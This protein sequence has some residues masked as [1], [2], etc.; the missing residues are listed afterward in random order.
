MVIDRMLLVQRSST[1]LSSS[2]NHPQRKLCLF[3][4]LNIYSDGKLQQLLNHGGPVSIAEGRHLFGDIGINSTDPYLKVALNECKAS[5][6]KNAD[7]PNSQ[8][9]VRK[10]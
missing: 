4:R 9:V 8:V 1:I 7:D 2:R 10:G 3:L 6:T 5:P